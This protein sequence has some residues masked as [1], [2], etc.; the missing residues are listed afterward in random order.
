MRRL[1]LRALAAATAAAACATAPAALAGYNIWTGEYTFTREELQR[2]LAQR[3]PATLR[4]GELL[5]VQLSHPRLTLDAGA[6]RVTTLVD[7]RLT[8]TVLG[9]PPVDGSL[10]L[11]SG[12]R[13]D[14]AR[15]AVLLDQPTLQQVQVAGLPPQYREPL[16]AIGA[17]A[18][19]QLLQDYPL[20]TFTPEQL[21]V[22]GQEVEPGAIT[23][24]DDGI[25]VQIKPR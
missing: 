5:S 1:A 9:G 3:F 10:A 24:S 25:R 14:P 18:A 17:A 4:Y 12:I 23:V 7:A 6:N 19:S 2:A 20:Y 22:G 13:Y 21:H 15:R 11:T 16:N 8:N